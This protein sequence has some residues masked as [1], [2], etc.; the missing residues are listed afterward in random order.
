MDSNKRDTKGDE[1]AKDENLTGAFSTFWKKQQERK[2]QRLLG[3]TPEDEAGTQGPAAAGGTGKYVPPSLARRIAQGG[4]P[5]GGGSMMPPDRENATLRV[6]NISSETKEADL[7]ELFKIFGSIM[8]IYLAKHRDT[9]ESRGFAYIS[10][11][12]REDA[13]RARSELDGHGY[14][15]L[16]LKLEW[17]KPSNPDEKKE[18]GL[19]GGYTSGYGK[20]LAQDTNL[21]VTTVDQAAHNASS[22]GMGP[23]RKW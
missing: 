9:N 16:I 7:H 14:D 2:Q 12:N 19:S 4:A 20:Q 10:Y 11:H 23:G 15:H 18:G 13:E 17:A 3:V 8:R 5:G 6:S 22:G 1:E 21:K